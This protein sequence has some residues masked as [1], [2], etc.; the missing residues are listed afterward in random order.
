MALS[1]AQKRDFRRAIRDRTSAEEVIDAID[2]DQAGTLSDRCGNALR[3]RLGRR[4]G[5]DL[6][7]VVDSA[8]G[9]ELT[10]A[11]THRLRHEMRHKLTAD[12]FVATVNA[13]GD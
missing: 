10:D 9:S 12:E 4:E 2:A 7:A 3:M 11:T 8:D 6:I 5:N 13:L 1:D